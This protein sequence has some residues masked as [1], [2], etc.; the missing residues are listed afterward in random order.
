[1]THNGSF[2]ILKDKDCSKVACRWRCHSVRKRGQN[3]KSEIK[4][5]IVNVKRNLN[6]SVALFTCDN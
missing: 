2:F 6:E 4:M 5:E 3:S 1:M